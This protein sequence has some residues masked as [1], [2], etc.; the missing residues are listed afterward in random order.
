MY[1]FLGKFLQ[2]NAKLP[3]DKKELAQFILLGVN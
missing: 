2:Y 1:K 3:A